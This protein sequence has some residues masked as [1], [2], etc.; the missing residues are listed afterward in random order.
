MD[1]HQERNLT[2]MQANRLSTLPAFTRAL[3]K[4]HL[5]AAGHSYE[6]LDKPI[7][8][9]ANSWNEFNHGHL[10]QR[11]V[12]DKVKAGVRAAGGLP[13]EFHT[14]GPCDGLAVG[15]GGMRFILPSRDII[16]DSIEATIG[17][18][19]IFDGLVL[20]SNCDKITPGMLMA[21]ARLRMPA[22]H[23]SAGPAV[24]TIAFD[25]SKRLRAAFLD[26]D[27]SEKE[28]AEG[29]ARLYST[30]GN[31]PYIGTANT[32]NCL[33]EALG[34][35]LPG[36]ALIPA[37][38]HRR[39]LAAENTGRQIVKLVE[40][41]I[42]SDTILTGDAFTNAVRVAAAIG[43]STNYVLHLPAIAAELGIE[44][45][46]GDIDAIN[47]ST[48]LLCRIAPNG[49]QSV[50]DLDAAGGVPAI[51]H[52]LRGLLHLD[53]LTIL[54]NS[55]A[56]QLEG[57]RVTDLS[58]IHH[59]D[60]PLEREGGI[61][62]LTGN[63]AP[64]GAI[65][66][67]S[68]VPSD[69]HQFRGPARV[70]TSEEDCIAALSAGE[71]QEGEVLVIAYEGPK[72]GP[73]MREMHRLIGVLRA[74]GSRV[75]LVTDGRFS[76]AD[77]GLIVGHVAPE[78]AEAGPIAAVRDGDI[79]EIDLEMRKLN[80]ILPPAEITRRLAA[81]EPLVKPDSSPLLAKYRAMG[82]IS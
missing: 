62:V 18:H 49:S 14:I 63:L 27:L 58:V 8:G 24:P 25:E 7:I 53:A 72:G 32:M 16:A 13:I 30:P 76:G 37:G 47:R 75:A 51:M 1:P 6:D 3:L 12:A 67:R 43:G 36:S 44:L 57:V 73:G 23:L 79:I 10:S 45:T 56:D 68:A 31:C 17:G 4:S 74:T 42:R 33:A 21:A 28:L 41:G 60:K 48:P 40:M 81:F 78:A 20:I 34:M 65:V 82:R 71:A 64:G 2:I 46:L 61:V 19:P 11:E 9:V 55:L 59:F 35:A 22:I 66:K 80:L 54:G 69:L 38:T 26:G 29:N 5:I 52:E 70:F 39:M 15:S 77:G 50:V